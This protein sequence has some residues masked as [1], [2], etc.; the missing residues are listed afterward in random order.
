MAVV[1]FLAGIGGALARGF[2]GVSQ[3]C[4]AWVNSNGYT[5]PRE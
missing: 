5:H 3:D 4:E 1:A 2:W